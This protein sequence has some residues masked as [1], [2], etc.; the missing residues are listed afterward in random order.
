MEPGAPAE[1]G[2]ERAQGRGEPEVVERRGAQLAGEAQQL[3]HRLRGHALGL[4]QLGSQLGRSVL[5][6]GLQAQ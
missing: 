5:R 6:G 3:L 2:H 4:A 1:L